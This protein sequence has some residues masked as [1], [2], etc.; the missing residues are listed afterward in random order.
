MTASTAWGSFASP[1]VEAVT[2]SSGSRFSAGGGGGGGWCALAFGFGA[3]LAGAL[4]AAL[5]PPCALPAL[6]AAF[7]AAA[8]APAFGGPA[9]ALPAALPCA[10]ALGAGGALV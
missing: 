10:F 6:P 4:P 7:F 2:S 5:A 3:A 9:L 8:L 1:A